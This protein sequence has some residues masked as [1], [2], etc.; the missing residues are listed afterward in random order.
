MEKW[1][2]RFANAA[3]VAIAVTAVL[4]IA[5]PRREPDAKLLARYKEGDRIELQQVKTS[6]PTLL[7][8]TRSTC[9]FCTNSMPFYKT[10]ADLPVI[11]LATGEDS[12]TNRRYLLAN[13]VKADTVMTVQEASVTK[14]G[15]TPTIILIDG[16]GFIQRE[17]L[18]LLGPEQQREVREELQRTIAR[19]SFP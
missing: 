6:G 12:E 8:V 10:L 16:Q 17:W 11:W 7:I 14:V 5:S 2:N 3:V 1:L 15:G 18:G 13:G 4:A 19:K 9:G